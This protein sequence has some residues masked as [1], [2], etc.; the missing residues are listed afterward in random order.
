[1]LLVGV[2]TG[3]SGLARLDPENAVLRPALGAAGHVT[4]VGP[5]GADGAYVVEDGARIVRVRFGTDEREVIF[6]PCG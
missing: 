3:W 2:E 4:Y 5:A 6:P 1:V